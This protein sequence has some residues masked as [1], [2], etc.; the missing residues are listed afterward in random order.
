MFINSLLLSD[1]ECNLFY[2]AFNLL[3]LK[4]EYQRKQVALYSNLKELL[5]L[6]NTGRWLRG[7]NYLN[8]LPRTDYNK[9]I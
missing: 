4:A 6:H 2:L 1:R 5:I 9:N 8:G 3:S 7:D